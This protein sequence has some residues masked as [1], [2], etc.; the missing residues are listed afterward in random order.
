MGEDFLAVPADGQFGADPQQLSRDV[1][2]E[3]DHVQVLVVE[4][5]PHVHAGEY[6][7][8]QAPLFEGLLCIGAGGLDAGTRLAGHLF[9]GRLVTL[10][11]EV[12]SVS[13]RICDQFL[14]AVLA[15]EA[16]PLETFEQQPLSDC[17]GARDIRK[18]HVFCQPLSGQVL[19]KIEKEILQA[20]VP[21]MSKRLGVTVHGHEDLVR[22]HT[23]VRGD[24]GPYGLDP[25][26]QP[27]PPHP[28]EPADEELVA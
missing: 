11:Q 27:V 9:G 17:H 8:E 21:V 18:P 26:G 12:G 25:F 13:E 28:V 3:P 23:G 7:V 14:V 24:L 4:H 1:L 19:V 16:R 22:F 6:L 20:H 10:Q 15:G 5:D 2:V